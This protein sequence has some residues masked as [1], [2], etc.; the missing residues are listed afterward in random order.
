MVEWA[1]KIVNVN[2]EKHIEEDDFDNTILIRVM[3][4]T[5]I[6]GLLHS[7]CNIEYLPS[8]MTNTVCVLGVHNRSFYQNNPLIA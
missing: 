8:I 4:F 3:H 1:T 7:A 6:L 5:L 2:G